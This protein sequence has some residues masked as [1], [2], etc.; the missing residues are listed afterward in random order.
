MELFFGFESMG[1]NSSLMSP[2]MQLRSPVTMLHS[3][4]DG[5]MFGSAY[6]PFE[7]GFFQQAAE[8]NKANVPTIQTPNY[9]GLNTPAEAL[10]EFGSRSPSFAPP[11]TS[12]WTSEIFRSVTPETQIATPTREVNTPD[13][14]QAPSLQ[15]TALNARITE[16]KARRARSGAASHSKLPG[17]HGRIEKKPKGEKWHCEK[18]ADRKG[19]KHEDLEHTCSKAYARPHDMVRHLDTVAKTYVWRCYQPGCED[20]TFARKDALSRHVTLHEANG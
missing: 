18:S 13:R 12:G 10:S 4:T 2:T 1:N 17:A 14:N 15:P 20:K 9:F 16:K 19:W 6:D 11:S 8:L 7:I 3:A 5:S